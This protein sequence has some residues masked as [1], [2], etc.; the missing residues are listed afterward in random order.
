[1]KRIFIVFLSLLLALLLL[2]CSKS[3]GDLASDIG[4][5][6]YVWEKEGFGGN[7]TITLNAD[8]TYQYYAGYL[9]SYIGMGEWK[10]EDGV[11]TMTE[12]SGYD[13]VFRFSVKD[14]ELVYI[15]EGSSKYMYVTVGD[16]DRFILTDG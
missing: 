14:G 2:S 16:G 6:T 12:N 9:S 10:V 7:F 4:G 11:L 15:K 13:L 8:G 5:K 1:M 3:E